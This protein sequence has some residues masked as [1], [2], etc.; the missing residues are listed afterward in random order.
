MKKFI[1]ILVFLLIPTW[2]WSACT[3]SSPTW[4]ATADSSSLNTCITNA[5]AGDTIN[6]NSGSFSWTP[7]TLT[8]HI[9]IIGGNGGTTT[10][11]LG[12]TFEIH[13]TTTGADTLVRVSGFT[14]NCGSADPCILLGDWAYSG[15]AGWAMMYNV[16]FDHNI[17]TNISGYAMKS[18]L[19]FY[20]VIDNNKF[21]TSASDSCAEYCMWNE[22]NSSATAANNFW[23]TSPQNLYGVGTSKYHY[24]EDNI[25]YSKSAGRVV[26]NQWDAR[27]VFRYNT[28]YAA[29]TE[30]QF[31]IHGH[32]SEDGGD[33]GFA[34]E[35]YGNNIVG[36]CGIANIRSGENMI[37]YNNVS[38][39]VPGIQVY[40]DGSTT[41]ASYQPAL[42]MTHG[43][44]Y[45]QNRQNN[46]GTLQTASDNGY[47]CNYACGGNSAPIPQSGRDYFYNTSTPGITAG[48]VGSLPGTC[49]TGQGYWATT[50]STTNLTGLVGDINTYPT[51]STITGSLYKCTATNTWTEY[52][53]P[54]TYPHPLRGATVLPSSLTGILSGG[55][56]R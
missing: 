14:F 21:G 1:L 18:Y 9:S 29:G 43:N 52:Y 34:Y 38:A 44:Y 10:I 11:T 23:H 48:V 50:Q 30:A 49:T 46:T 32:Q 36:N 12:G 35:I 4:A 39:S 28:V 55:T 31:E 22:V 16:R 53:I 8:K 40:C 47:T 17:L 25:F 33:G 56:L 6:V 2:S 15:T 27:G 45:W 20:G 41:C 26:V 42:Q 54:Y 37:Y 19:T 5:A 51:R 7:A 24:Y 13:P 3:G